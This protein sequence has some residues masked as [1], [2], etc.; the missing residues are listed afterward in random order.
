MRDILDELEVKLEDKSMFEG[1]ILGELT[2]LTGTLMKTSLGA[3]SKMKEGFDN[4]L[5]S[6]EEK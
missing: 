5:K 4:A 3:L 1:S 6:D 2:K